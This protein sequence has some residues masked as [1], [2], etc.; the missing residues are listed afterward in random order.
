MSIRPR[1][2]VLY[3][4]GSN[5]RAM[6]KAKTLPADVVVL[7]LEDSVGP[8]KKSEARQA[9]LDAVRGG[10]YG[11]RELIIR[12]NSLDSEWGED[13]LRA[14]AHSGVAGVCL[15]KVESAEE[16]VRVANL[17][18][19]SGAPVSMA[20]WSMIETPAGVMNCA[21]IAASH[22]RLKVLVMGTTDL[23][24]ELRVAHTRDRIGLL[25]SLGQCVL[26]ARLCG[27]EILDGVYI[28][29]Q[30]D[31]GFRVACEQGRDLGFDGKTLIHPRQLD[32]ANTVFGPSAADVE[33]AHKVIA[34]WDEAEKAGKG[35]AVV[36]GKLVE[37]MHLDESRRLLA[38]ADA[39][40]QL[41]HQA[42]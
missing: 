18:E 41:G 20:I 4:P 13:D 21:A 5:A 39:I 40:E 25:F 14:V 36:D 8:E 9:V 3:M 12:I 16:V 1:R 34:A 23:A 37:T 26:A 32:V 29:L 6:E 11:H 10:G 7:D 22:D 19:E 31:D 42:R 17:L 30:D 28:D 27:R 24:K 35:V 38:I 33:R 2:S 15:P